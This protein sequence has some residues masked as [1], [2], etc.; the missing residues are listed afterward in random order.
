MKKLSIISIAALAAANIATPAFA[1]VQG[2][3]TGFSASGLA[4]INN[5]TAYTCNLT[6]TG[7]TGASVD[8][9]PGDP[10]YNH[11]NSG[12]YTGTNTGTFPCPLITVSGNFANISGGTG[13]V[14]N[15]K[16]FVNN[17][18]TCQQAGTISFTYSGSSPMNILLPTTYLTNVATGLQTCEVDADLDTYDIG[19]VS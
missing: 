16:V 4:S 10:H 15:L 5:G 3:N 1:H 6:L 9:N 2:A 17:V 18:L 14:T 8:P 19:A 7:T 13:N 12:T 11:A